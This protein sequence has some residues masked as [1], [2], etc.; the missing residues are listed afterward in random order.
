MSRTLLIIALFAMG[1]AGNV[2]AW[3]EFDGK[4][5]SGYDA[6]FNVD[7]TPIAIMVVNAIKARWEPSVAAYLRLKRLR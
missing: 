3:D 5:N 2:H 6:V 1:L 7:Y 4:F